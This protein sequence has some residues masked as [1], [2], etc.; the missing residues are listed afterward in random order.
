MVIHELANGWDS[1]TLGRQRRFEPGT[2]L[3]LDHGDYASRSSLAEHLATKPADLAVLTCASVIQ[4][5]RSGAALYA[6]SDEWALTTGHL[7]IVRSVQEGAGQ[8][9]W[10]L[11]ATPRK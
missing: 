10:L 8:V 5:A 11:L 7:P 1:A 9:V 4:V 6:G 3:E 2:A